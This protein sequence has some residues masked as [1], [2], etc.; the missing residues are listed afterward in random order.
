MAVVVN[1]QVKATLQWLA[2]KSDRSKRWI[3]TCPP[4]GL[5]AEGDSLDD[6]YGRI[7]EV[8]HALLIDLV[9]DNEFDQFLREKGWRSTPVKPQDGGDM[10][11]Q[12]P[13][14]LVASGYHG[15]AHQT[16]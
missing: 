11:F 16:H 5:A 3:A 10:S 15:S 6:L 4:L 14:E 12:V 2:E 1:I 7:D 13:W 8:L 9:E